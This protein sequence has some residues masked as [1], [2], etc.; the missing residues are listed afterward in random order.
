M[1]GVPLHARGLQLRIS[2]QGLRDM[3]D[4]LLR[5][6]NNADVVLCEIPEEDGSN[7]E[8]WPLKGERSIQALM[9]ALREETVRILDPNDV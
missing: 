9:D 7:A 1:T 2:E 4:R 8:F 3:A 5:R 6:L